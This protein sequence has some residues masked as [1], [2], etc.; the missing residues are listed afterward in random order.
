LAFGSVGK[1]L[2]EY[3]SMQG[4]RVRSPDIRPNGTLHG[5]GFELN[6]VMEDFRRPL[7]NMIIQ[8]VGADQIDFAHEDYVGQVIRFDRLRFR[9]KNIPVGIPK[10][11]KANLFKGDL[12]TDP[13]IYHRFGKWTLVFN[14]DPRWITTSTAFTLFRPSSGASVFTGFGRIHSVDLENARMTATALAVG[15][16]QSNFDLG[17]GAPLKQKA[18]EVDFRSLEDDV[19][20]S[21][22]GRWTGEVPNCD[23]C[24]RSF[25][26][27]KYMVDGP[28]RRNGPWGCMC[29]NCY[30][31]SCLPLGIGKGQLYRWE[32]KIWRLVGGYAEA[33]KA[34]ED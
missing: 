25:D 7:E 4:F 11:A 21:R 30:S 14:I 20:L 5:L 9:T 31:K 26:D 6:S 1:R 8:S 18:D 34:N 15:I 27:E 13:H 3:A 2:V 23:F 29:G 33:P 12:T 32:R 28:M 17:R 19:T 10:I 22:G 24:G 16:P